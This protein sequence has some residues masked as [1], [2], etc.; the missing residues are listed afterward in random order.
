M[1]IAYDACDNS[2][3]Y[4]LLADTKKAAKRGIMEKQWAKEP[5]GDK[6]MQ[7]KVDEKNVKNRQIQSRYSYLP[8]TVAPVRILLDNFIFCVCV[9]FSLEIIGVTTYC[10]FV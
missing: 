9:C 6:D 3:E 1:V 7:V 4:M 8:T 10:V 2:K 5:V